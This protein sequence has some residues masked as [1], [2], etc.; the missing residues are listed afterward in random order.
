MTE[1]N[2]IDLIQYI[3]KIKSNNNKL[4]WKLENDLL[5]NKFTQYISLNESVNLKTLENDNNITDIKKEKNNNIINDDNKQT[6]TEINDDNNLRE[7]VKKKIDDNNI[8]L[9]ENKTESFKA[10]S[11]IKK[12]LPL[13]LLSTELNLIITDD[14]YNYIKTRITKLLEDKKYIKVFGVKKT[15]EIVSGIVNNKWNIS[16]VL[17]M[18]F[19]L[20]KKFIYLKKEI[21]FNKELISYNTISI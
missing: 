1:T 12:K 4:L 9:L 11:K 18:S 7:I 5:Y 10:K 8:E 2:C 16:L 14:T 17:F 20:D 19:L 6:G 15:A 13:E 21:L 3:T